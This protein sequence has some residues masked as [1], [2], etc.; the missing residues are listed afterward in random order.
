M[1]GEGRRRGPLL[2][3]AELP[4]DILAWAD[5]L[6]RAHYPPDRNR[7]AAHVTLFHGLPPSAER[8]IRATLAQAATAHASPRAEIA[9]IMPLGGGTALKVAS[10]GMVAIH[11]E[12]ADTFH[13]LLTQQDSHPLVLHITVQN[14]VTQEAAKRLQN[15]LKD[16]LQPR[17][18][19]FPALLLHEYRDGLWDFVQAWR[20]RGAKGG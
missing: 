1:G 17:K 6:R 13:G 15:V 16:T 12:L 11:R 18:F 2:V 14:K 4:P 5:G 3:T 20:F 10:L 7:I 8:E 9:G 19:A